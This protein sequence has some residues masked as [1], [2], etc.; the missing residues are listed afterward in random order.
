MSGVGRRRSSS[1]HRSPLLTRQGCCIFTISNNHL[2]APDWVVNGVEPPQPNSQGGVA[3][4]R[5]AWSSPACQAQPSSRLTLAKGDCRTSGDP[6]RLK[7]TGSRKPPG[8]GFH[9][10]LTRHARSRCKSRRRGTMPRRCLVRRYWRTKTN[11]RV[12]KRSRHRLAILICTAHLAEL[13]LFYV[14]PADVFNATRVDRPCGID[15]RQRRPRSAEYRDASAISSGHGR[16]LRVNLS[17][18]GKPLAVVIPS[19][20]SAKAE[21]GVET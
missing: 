10:L 12:M 2:L 17:K 1:A 5:T 15:K 13:D 18:S 9:D 19:Q 7:E 4:Y 8:I 16:N 21:E 6:R 14:F 11:R 3:R 20:A